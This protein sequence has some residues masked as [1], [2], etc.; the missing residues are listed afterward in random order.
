MTEV[1][2]AAAPAAAQISAVQGAQMLA[3]RRAANSQSQ[4]NTSEAARILGQRAAEARAQARQ[5]KAEAE[6][7]EAQPEEGEAELQAEDKASAPDAETA[8]ESPSQEQDTSQDDPAADE[9]EDGTID[10]GEGVRLTKQEIRDGILMRAQFTKNS[11]ELG[12]ERK[13]LETI[14]TQKVAQLDTALLAVQ[15]LLPQPK[16][17]DVLIDELGLEEGIKAFAQ[18]QRMWASFGKALEGR[19]AEQAQHLESL[20]QSTIKQLSEKHG[21]KAASVFS[22]AVQYVASKTG[23]DPKQVEALMAHPEAVEMV[24]DA[25]TYRELK[26]KEPDVKRTIAEKPKVTRPGAKVSAQATAFSATQTARAKLK[27]SG[28]LSDAVAYLQ[29]Q[30]KAKG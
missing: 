9:S 22:D 7:Q 16:D 21:D 26:S 8:S 27:S 15:S 25:M 18:Q 12:E 5:A 10:L 2:P 30:R 13:Q 1:A 11:M 28:S 4:T 6:A 3:E 14:R 19:Q 20:K 24:K 23:T 17:Q 29:A